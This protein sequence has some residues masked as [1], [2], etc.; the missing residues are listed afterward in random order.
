[1]NTYYSNATIFRPSSLGVGS[2]DGLRATS[3]MSSAGYLQRADICKYEFLL[4]RVS[5]G[6]IY[7]VTAA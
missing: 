7:S 2:K 6:N 5:Y 3:K 1:M 4:L